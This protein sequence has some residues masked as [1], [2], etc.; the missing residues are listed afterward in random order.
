MATRFSLLPAIMI[1]GIIYSDIKVRGYD[2]DEFLEYLDRLT[3]RMNPYPGPRSVLF[4][5]NCRIHHV[6]GVEELCAARYAFG[7]SLLHLLSDN[8]TGESN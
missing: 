5:D 1:D 7:V 4:I 6:E 8:Y 2:G 3:A